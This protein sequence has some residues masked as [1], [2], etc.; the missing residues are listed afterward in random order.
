MKKN[1]TYG[2]KG[3]R[4]ELLESINLKIVPKNSIRKK[5]DRG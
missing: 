5:S 1:L 3:M 2:L 4:K